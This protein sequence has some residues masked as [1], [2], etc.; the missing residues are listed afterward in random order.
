MGLSEMP[1]ARLTELKAQ[2]DEAEWKRLCEHCVKFLQP[3]GDEQP[4]TFLP[5]Q[6]NDGKSIGA[7]RDSAIKISMR[8]MT[9]YCLALTMRFRG[10]G[11][12]IWSPEW[13]TT[14][15]GFKSQG[16]V[17]RRFPK[18]ALGRRLRA[19]KVMSVI[20]FFRDGH[21][22][23]LLVTPAAHAGHQGADVHRGWRSSSINRGE[24]KGTAVS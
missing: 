18:E 4:D 14:Y 11:I 17:L 5:R 6:G 23:L 12:D 24:R 1:R 19:A 20:P 13:L 16:R 15:V 3:L 2:G 22:T 8:F 9:A 10:L 21:Y 7:V